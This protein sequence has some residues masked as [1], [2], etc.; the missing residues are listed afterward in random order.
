MFGDTDKEGLLREGKANFSPRLQQ[1]Q[2][3]PLS[4]KTQTQ[5]GEIKR[6]KKHVTSHEWEHVGG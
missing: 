4:Q 3:S 2:P 5:V 6:K 1:Q